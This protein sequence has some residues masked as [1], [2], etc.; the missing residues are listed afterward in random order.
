MSA[1]VIVA[2][3]LR[4]E[5]ETG[6]QTHFQTYLSLLKA[7]QR[8]G[9]LVTPYNAPSWLV[10]PIF[11]VRRLI[12]PVNGTASAKW[13]R[14]WHALFLERALR[15]RLAAQGPCVIYAQ[16]PLS[17]AAA[18][19][20][21]TSPQQKVV[22][23]VHFNVS[24]ADEWAGKKIISSDGSLARA[25][26]TFE[27][28][29]L[30]RVDGLV[31][32]SEFMRNILLASIPSIRHVPYAVVPNFLPDPG[33]R[34]ANASIDADL[35]TV[36]GLESRKNQRYALEILAEA[37]AAGQRLT[38]TIAGGGPDRASLEARARELGIESSVRFPGFV[39]N[40]AALFER[41]RACLHV[42]RME[43]FPITLV[44]ALSRGIPVF[45]P[46]VGGVPEV[47]SDGVEG[48]YLPLDEPRRAAALVCEWFG[49]ESVLTRAGKAAR[50]RFLSSFQN[51]VV[52]PRLTRFMD[53]VVASPP[54]SPA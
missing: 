7:S 32:V 24:Q 23:V 49:D 14:H 54:S 44:E 33:E 2:T 13:F 40:A 3:V 50:Q 48:R 47:F 1:E 43:N 12:D 29:T 35:L 38:L 25:I 15:R 51:N 20:A 19:Q 46:A 41:H 28:E 17:A 8:R 31:F 37:H 11:A 6:V 45:A 10:Y 34:E 53:E 39:R 22:L 9:S 42:A 21:R 16:C 26:R 30:P 36:G 4:P 5:G 52:A 18:L 27:A